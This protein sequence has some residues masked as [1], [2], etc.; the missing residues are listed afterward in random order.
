MGV[1][2]DFFNAVH[3]RNEALA[4]EL[5]RRHGLD[6]NLLERSG[7]IGGTHA[8]ALAARFGMH[9]LMADLITRGADARL[10][11]DGLAPIH[12]AADARAIGILVAAGADPNAPW[13][14]EGVDMARGTT[15]LHTAARDDRPELIEALLK[16]GADPN[17]RDRD[18]FTPLHYAASRS[19]IVARQLLAAGAGDQIRTASGLTA[20]ELLE[21]HQPGLAN[22]L[23]LG[24]ARLADQL[25]KGGA[26]PNAIGTGPKV[27]PVPQTT[28]LHLA[29]M[30][31]NPEMASLLLEYG[32]NP[33]ALDGKGLAPVHYATGQSRALLEALVK[34]G[35]DLQLKT[36]EGKTAADLL[37]Q[38][39]PDLAAPAVSPQ[40]APAV[41]ANRTTTVSAAP[42]PVAARASE[43][44]PAAP[45]P[46]HAAPA[47]SAQHTAAVETMGSSQSL[48]DDA[49]LVFRKGP[50]QNEAQH[51][52]QTQSTAQSHAEA[53][54][55]AP[56]AGKSLLGGQFVG[57]EKGEYVRPGEKRVALV[58]AGGQ[59]ELK[60]RESDTV[61]AGVELAKEKGWPSIEVGGGTRFRREAWLA[62]AEAGIAVIGYEPS[63]KD[64]EE[65]ER[66]R[67]LNSGGSLK[68][69][70]AVPAQSATP[71]QVPAAAVSDAGALDASLEEAKKAALAAGKKFMAA[72]LHDR[73][74]ASKVFGETEH[75]VLLMADG[76]AN[77][78]TAIEKSKLQG[79]PVEVGKMLKVRFKDGQATAQAKT[80]GKKLSL[81]R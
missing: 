13:K 8:L 5:L 56:V 52:A 80:E 2:E 70:P 36:P 27:R 12:M 75:H 63:Q 40:R 30:Y 74:Y 41:G 4:R 19:E 10:Y 53:A 71:S 58:D 76:R 44:R 62:A 61:A 38:F 46:A 48:E 68:A 9:G 54:K 51:V 24:S 18:G 45:T 23:G 22:E 15:A 14:R 81:S 20:R 67:K 17:V 69:G 79:I 7:L 33:N 35:A 3:A 64:H 55:A 16:A 11:G 29:A 65:L 57:N 21:Q 78:A 32:A 28:P 25:L 39:G 26:Q 49:P 77:T 59:I 6:P 31:D 34:G 60:D 47:A 1:R 66:R 37:A 42:A 50:A 43:P 72:D 73:T